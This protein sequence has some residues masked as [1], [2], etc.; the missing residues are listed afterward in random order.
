MKK[1]LYLF[2]CLILFTSCDNIVLRKDRNERVTFKKNIVQGKYNIYFYELNYPHNQND[3]L[4]FIAHFQEIL[5]KKAKGNINFILPKELYDDVE[6]VMN[7]G[8]I[9]IEKSFF[10][11]ASFLTK[12]DLKNINS[13]ARYVETPKNGGTIQENL[14]RQYYCILRLLQRED[15]YN[16]ESYYTEYD[17]V[18]LAKEFISKRKQ[19]KS[20][21]LKNKN[22]FLVKITQN[23]DLKNYKNDMI[24]IENCDDTF[25]DNIVNNKKHISSPLMLLENSLYTGYT[26]NNNSLVLFGGYGRTKLNYFI[27][28]EFETTIIRVNDLRDIY[29]IADDK[30]LE[31]STLLDRSK[32]TPKRPL[33]R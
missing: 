24:Y 5:D 31:I 26:M 17:K 20:T 28:Y 3:K 6:S 2:I 9:G 22:N 21:L 7:D 18:T 12:E 10:K 32:Y 15:E 8:G 11:D 25:V 14:N 13:K 29:F 27:G 19:L 33:S 1:I 23:N 4:S 30:S 16:K